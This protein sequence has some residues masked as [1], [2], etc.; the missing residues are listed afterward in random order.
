MDGLQHLRGSLIAACRLLLLEMIS[1]EYGL[2]MY[3]LL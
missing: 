3:S 2:G 1:Y